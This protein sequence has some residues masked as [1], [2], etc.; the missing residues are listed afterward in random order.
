MSDYLT[1]IASIPLNSFTKELQQQL[2]NTLQPKIPQLDNI[3]QKIKLSAYN[4]QTAPTK[5]KRR[6]DELIALKKQLK[7]EEIVHMERLNYIPII[8]QIREFVINRAL[9]DNDYLIE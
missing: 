3:V 4:Y 6:I 7:E 8:P 2:Y 1:F 9:V 5:Q